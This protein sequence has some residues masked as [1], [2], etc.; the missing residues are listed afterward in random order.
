MAAQV[1]A[2]DEAR[3]RNAELAD[4]NRRLRSS[5]HAAEERAAAAESDAASGAIGVAREQLVE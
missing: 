3:E 4:E 5:L 2:A 1:A